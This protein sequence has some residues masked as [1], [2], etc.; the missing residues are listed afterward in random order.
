M[1]NIILKIPFLSY[2]FVGGGVPPIK[3]VGIATFER[4]FRKT[5]LADAGF[6]TIVLKQAGLGKPVRL[7]RQV[8]FLFPAAPEFR[9]DRRTSA[10]WRHV[11]LR[12]LRARRW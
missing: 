4:E 3:I 12:L 7:T 11:L 5:Q 8:E 9:V 2:S 6:A 10:P 1:A